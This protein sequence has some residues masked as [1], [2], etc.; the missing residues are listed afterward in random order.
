MALIGSNNF[1]GRRTYFEK[2]EYW[3]VD[4]VGTDYATLIH[5]KSSDG[6]FPCKQLNAHT[7]QNS[8]SNGM[9]QYSNASVQL[10]TKSQINI[11]QNDL[12]KFKEIYWI[13]VNVQVRVIGRQEQFRKKPNFI[14]TI[15]LRG[16][17][18]Q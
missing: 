2:A 7:F 6:S 9:F 4:N 8:V 12:V 13:V 14:T 1:L 17:D 5:K 10:E 3:K 15:L 16:T 18:Y 11:R